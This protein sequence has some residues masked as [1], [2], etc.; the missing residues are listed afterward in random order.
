VVTNVD[1]GGK[2]TVTFTMR[3]TG[4]VSPGQQQTD[5][6]TV[7]ATLGGGTDSDNF[8]ATIKG[9]Q[10]TQA[11]SVAQVSGT[12]RDITSGTPIKGAVGAQKAAS[13]SGPSTISWIIL[14]LAGLLVLLGVGVFV[15]LFINRKKGDAED[16][17]GDGGPGGPHGSPMPPGGGVYGGAPGASPTMVG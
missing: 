13:N 1:G 2:K 6:G 17:E 16:E 11:P 3:A 15:V 4:S 8:D 10:P 9:G 5:H 7:T 12:V 14:V